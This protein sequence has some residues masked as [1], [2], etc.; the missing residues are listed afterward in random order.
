MVRL[1]YTVSPGQSKLHRKVASK[2]KTNNNKKVS[3]IKHNK[4]LN[5]QNKIYEHFLC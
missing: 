5:K 3:F 1:V 4:F 2:K